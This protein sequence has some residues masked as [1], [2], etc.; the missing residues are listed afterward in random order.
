MYIAALKKFQSFCIS[1]NTTTW[2]FPVTEYILCYFIAHLAD[3]GLL[4]Q[5]DKV[6]LAALCSMQISLSSLGLPA[7]YLSVLGVIIII[8]TGKQKLWSSSPSP[9]TRSPTWDAVKYWDP[10]A[11]STSRYMYEWVSRSTNLLLFIYYCK[12]I[13]WHTCMKL[14]LYYAS[15]FMFLYPI[16]PVE[17]C[18]FEYA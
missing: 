14:A 5:T 3:Q 8:H 10:A 7:P 18:V 4:P 2:S 16:S 15:W 12:R 1:Y 11:T 13:N 17:Y 6:Y 9:E